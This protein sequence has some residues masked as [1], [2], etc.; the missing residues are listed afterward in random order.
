MDE[1]NKHKNPPF[2]KRLFRKKWLV[3]I[4]VV[5]FVTLLTGGGYFIYNKYFVSVKESSNKQTAKQAD[6]EI[7]SEDISGQMYNISSKNGI[8]AGQRYLDDKLETA[9]DNAVKALVYIRKAELTSSLLGNHNYTKALE[10]SYKAESL[11][12]SADAALSIALYE[13]KS[14]NTANAIKYYKLYLE[15]NPKGADDAETNN[16]GYYTSRIKELESGRSHKWE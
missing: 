10:Y 8:D 1:N 11:S 7:T 14:G 12:P 16:F 15:R 13:D 2:L 9:N 3:V 5:I 4:I 6:Q